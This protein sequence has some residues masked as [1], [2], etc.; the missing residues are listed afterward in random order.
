MK[1]KLISILLILVPLLN[2]CSA[3]FEQKNKIQIVVL[4][5]II[6]VVI[7]IFLYKLFKAIYYNFVNFFKN[8]FK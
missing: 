6:I 7:L 5:I 8:F 1:T 4:I 3:G 2:S